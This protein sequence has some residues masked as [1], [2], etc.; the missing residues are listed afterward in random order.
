MR[1]PCWMA[2]RKASI[3]PAAMAFDS[4]GTLY[5]VSNFFN[6][7]RKVTSDGKVVT[8]AG[9][10]MADFKGD[11]GPALAAAFLY[12]TG[13]AIDSQ[14]N[15]YVADGGN[16]R[17]RKIDKFGKIIT[18]AWT[19]EP[20]LSGDG[21]AAVKAMLTYPV[22]VAVDGAGNLFVV[23]AG[24]STVRRISMDGVIST[25]AGT[26]KVGR[27]GDHASATAVDLDLGEGLTIGGKGE[28]YITDNRYTG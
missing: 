13:I 22:S 3:D 16:S 4:T 15:I 27:S 19:G 25:I 9:T 17:V 2:Q 10:G 23:D 21:G 12:P 14:D 5:F 1:L 28:L 11:G 26:G 24:N 18:V 6:Q 8:V 7:V 20:G